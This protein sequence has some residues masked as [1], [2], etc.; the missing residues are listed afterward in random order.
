MQSKSWARFGCQKGESVSEFKPEPS[1][2]MG[3]LRCADALSR[4]FEVKIT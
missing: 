2:F 3:Y 1:M 4:F